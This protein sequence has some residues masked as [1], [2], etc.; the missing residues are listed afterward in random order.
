MAKKLLNSVQEKWLKDN[1]HL[2]S[3][4]D[5]ADKLSEM[6]RIENKKSIDRLEKLLPD[7]TY[8]PTRKS[9]EHQI[10]RMK[11]FKG[12]TEA[13]VR[14]VATR[15]GCK[16]KSKALISEYSRQKAHDTNLKKWMKKARKVDNIAAYLRTM[17]AREIRIC[18]VENLTHLNTFRNAIS[19]FN[20]GEGL[21]SGVEIFNEYISEANLLRLEARVNLRS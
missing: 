17:R 4:K 15:I 7:V 9:V 11:S 1:Y 13:Y 12:F 10:K 6:V 3:N 2:K 18:I 16:P 21:E 5:L 19:R 8:M 14:H 20:Q